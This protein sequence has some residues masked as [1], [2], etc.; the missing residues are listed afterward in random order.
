MRDKFDYLKEIVI[1]SGF[2]GILS[3]IISFAM[4]FER[5]AK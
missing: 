3:L 1:I 5:L 2:I 4:L